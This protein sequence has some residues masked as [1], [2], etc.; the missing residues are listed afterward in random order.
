MGKLM[1]TIQMTLDDELVQAVDEI[2]QSLNTTRSAFTRTALKEA[3]RQY[4]IQKQKQKHRQG[5]QRIPVQQDEFSVWEE[6]QAWEGKFRSLNYDHFTGKTSTSK[7]G[8]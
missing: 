6:E 2:V 7:E 3:I 5:Y 4:Q 8:D 1:R